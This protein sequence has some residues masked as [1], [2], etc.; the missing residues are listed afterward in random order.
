MRKR[1]SKTCFWVWLFF[2]KRL[3][4]K[5]PQNQHFEK[6]TLRAPTMP[7]K[8]CQNGLNLI[9]SQRFSL[10]ASVFCKLCKNI[11]W[12]SR[13]IRMILCIDTPI[14]TNSIIA[15]NS[16]N[17][18]FL[19]HLA[20]RWLI[21]RF[22]HSLKKRIYDMNIQVPP[23]DFWTINPVKTLPWPVNSDATILLYRMVRYIKIVRGHIFFT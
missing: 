22:S 2:L 9:Y 11:T 5:T 14:Y 15:I 13:T 3:L 7:G 18:E 6:K 8:R 12:S 21:V 20:S 17:C 23:L 10:V 1:A 16:L 19:C 4:R